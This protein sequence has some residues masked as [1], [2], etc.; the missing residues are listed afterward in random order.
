MLRPSL[1]MTLITP[2]VWNK[3][4]RSVGRSDMGTRRRVEQRAHP[5]SML[6]LRSRSASSVAAMVA[7]ALLLLVLLLLPAYHGYETRPPSSLVPRSTRPA[8]AAS[9]PTTPEAAARACG[10]G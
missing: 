7:A 9:Q 4:G 10:C 1:V 6:H 2:V 3:G 8:A 5:S